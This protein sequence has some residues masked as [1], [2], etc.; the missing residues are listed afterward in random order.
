MLKKDHRQVERLLQQFESAKDAK[1]KKALFENIRKELE[2]HTRL[3]EEV[4]YPEAEQRQELKEQVGEAH[5]E[6]D[7]VKQML[8]KA[9]GLDPDSGEFD[10]T[11][12]GIKGAV[13]HHVREE[14]DEMFPVIEKT[15]SADHL[16]EL[17]EKMQ[18]RRAQ[19]QRGNGAMGE[20]RSLVGRLMGR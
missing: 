15:F 7:T 18:S 4:F 6:H 3:E 8:R 9:A 1:K 11:V 19:L 2:L 20:G 5:G 10:S 16:R 17:G 12:A 14:E 13:E